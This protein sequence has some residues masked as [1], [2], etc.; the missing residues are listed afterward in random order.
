MRISESKVKDVKIIDCYYMYQNKKYTYRAIV[1]KNTLAALIIGWNLD[2]NT[3]VIVSARHHAERTRQGLKIATVFPDTLESSIEQDERAAVAV[4]IFRHAEQTLVQKNLAVTLD[5]DKTY[6]T[7]L[8][9]FIGA[10]SFK[11]LI[12]EHIDLIVAGEI[13]A[14]QTEMSSVAAAAAPGG[15]AQNVIDPSVTQPAQLQAVVDPAPLTSNE[16]T[17]DSKLIADQT[18][19]ELARFAAAAETGRR[20][21]SSAIDN[22]TKTKTKTKTK[23]REECEGAGAGLAQERHVLSV[24]KLQELVLKHNAELAAKEEA[25]RKVKEEAAEKARQ[26]SKI[27][28]QLQGAVKIKDKEI[29]NLSAQLRQMQVECD[30]ISGEKKKLSEALQRFQ[31]EI[32]KL[33][34]ELRQLTLENENTKAGQ[35][36]AEKARQEIEIAT[37][38]Q[39]RIIETKDTEIENLRA[40]LQG[41]TQALGQTKTELDD[42]KDER[43]Q[44]NAQLQETMARAASDI[45][46]LRIVH[47][48]TV[49]DAI[50]LTRR[51]EGERQATMLEQNWQ[52][53]EERNS[54]IVNLSTEL[55]QL[56]T[57]NQHLVARMGGMQAEHEQE[58]RR[59]QADHAEAMMGRARAAADHADETVEN[60]NGNGNGGN[61]SKLSN[62]AAA[63][64][65]S[66]QPVADAATGSAFSAQKNSCGGGRGN[67]AYDEVPRQLPRGRGRGRG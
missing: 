25:V 54:V 10:S 16:S 20:I 18:R 39:V 34:M 49:N 45:R 8:R 36:A 67:G 52:L 28:V 19:E 57:Y 41:A 55:N 63:F 14:Q 13:R 26:E 11:K 27:R 40:Q 44:L 22:L 66:Y 9:N 24:E 56:T 61:T 29:G 33:N 42:V 43:Q 5:S 48:R 65:N 38:L 32:V 17:V 31:S 60:R 47:R 53:V 3:R 2:D 58:I 50:E 15:A 23:I 37:A 59:M 64:L 1:H 46:S 21:I 4:S 7:P 6:P 30:K 51:I 62:F 12:E 35:T